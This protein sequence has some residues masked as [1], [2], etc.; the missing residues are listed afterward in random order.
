MGEE[1]FRFCVTFF[2]LLARK[3]QTSYL[4]SSTHFE[5]LGLK[6]KDGMESQ[7]FFSTEVSMDLTF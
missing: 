1:E 2:I 7:F 5:A 6:K 3:L 4:S